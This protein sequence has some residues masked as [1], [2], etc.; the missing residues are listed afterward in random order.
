VSFQHRLQQAVGTYRQNQG[1]DGGWGEDRF[2]DAPTSIVNTVEVLAVLRAGGVSYEDQ[3]V[4]R[5]LGYLGDA[6]FSHPEPLPTG[7]ETIVDEARGENTRYCAWGLCGLTLYRQS[8]HDP[9][10]GD[11]QRRCVEWLRDREWNNQGAWSEGP[12]DEHPSLLSTS[13]AITGLSRICGYHPAGRVAGELVTRA[14]RVVHSLANRTGG[15]GSGRA[16]SWSL[17]PGGDPRRPSPSATAMAVIALAGG[18]HEDR[19][20]A[21]EGATWLLRHRRTWAETVESDPT[22][23]YAN[24]QHMTFSLGLRAILRGTRR[25]SAD[26]QLRGTVR[27]L[28]ELW[29]VEDCEWAHG[30]P[31]ARPSPSG[32]YAVVTAY[33][34]MTKAWPFDAEREI[35][36]ERSTRGRPAMAPE[37]VVRVRADSGLVV[38]D[39]DGF[40][41][42]VGLPPTELE[43]VRLL[44]VRHSQGAGEDT[45]EARSLD[46][47]ELAEHLALMTDSV[48][49]YVQH[50]NQAIKERAEYHGRSIGDL[51]QIAKSSQGPSRRRALI[52]VDRVTVEG[53]IREL[54]GASAD[55]PDESDLIGELPPQEAQR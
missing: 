11:A 2:A 27:H 1:A 46:L 43:I 14:R 34:A 30:I 21:M 54:P 25:D 8:R 6:V 42:D 10:L 18:G 32:S 53:Q 13:A 24:W 26:P 33:E 17:V 31:G 55:E 12:S 19:T 50:V 51:L 4:R 45:I 36:R 35:L 37:T 48:R 23:P 41:F 3:T 20:L 15:D 49:R 47:R 52:N 40:S 22:A 39:L 38:T 16:S 28:D 9:S 5:A 29:R 7:E 44:A